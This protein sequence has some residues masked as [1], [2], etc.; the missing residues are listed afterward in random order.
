MYKLIFDKVKSIIPKI[1][2][3]E[4]IALR[5]GGVSIDRQIFS[6][7]VNYKTIKK[8]KMNDR[9]KKMVDLTDNILN[10]IGQNT[11]FPTNNYKDIMKTLGEKG[12]LSLIIDEKFGGNK[13]S[14]TAQSKIISKISS[15][16]PALG[17]VVMVPNSLGPAELLQHYGSSHQKEY[18]LP[19]LA[20]GELIPCFGLTGPNNGSDAVGQIDTGI[21]KLKN[22]KKVIEITLNKR[23]I[24]LAPISNLVGV[25]FN[26]KDPES[27]LLE[28]K[29]GITIALLK[30][31]TP[32]LL[33]NTFHNPNNVGFPNGT[34]K[35]TVDV[36]FTEVIGGEKQIGKGWPML[37]EC[38]AVGRG[39]SLPACANGSSKLITF[40][41][42][43]Y[44]QHRTQFKLP[45]GEMEGVKEKFINMFLQTWIIHCSVEFTNAILD[46]GSTPSVIT[47]IMKQQCTERGRIVLN[48]AMDIYAGSGICIGKNNF[49]TSFYNSTPIGITVEGSNTL[50]RSLIIFGQGLNKSHPHI[51]NIFDSIQNN[52]QSKFNLN[53]NK[54]LRDTILNY[55]SSCQ[56][57]IFESNSAERRLINLTTKFSN[58]SNFVALLG[59]KIKSNQMI[60]GN[61][62]DILSNIYLA[63]SVLWYH[64]NNPDLNLSN[65]KD[66][67]I[68]KLCIDA[69]HKL[70]LVIQNYPNNIIKVLLLP[71]QSSIRYN[72]FQKIN[73]IYESI[74]TNQETIK[75]IIK[76]D[77][78]YDK[79][80]IIDNLNNNLDSVINV[81][82]YDVNY[83]IE[84]K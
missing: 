41:I 83:V 57:G 67:V 48:E 51:F 16:N 55:L 9:E 17:V 37:M 84:L 32:G 11:Y 23:Y 21:V 14:I 8:I 26:L 39:V 81:G 31:T 72:N 42:L 62:A 73:E 65:V 12:F 79:D 64:E 70:N 13:I 63:Y 38:L 66:F 5:S 50:T 74:K 53:F 3:T 34:V 6:G 69:E 77:I 43:N 58:L 22:G 19:K 25:A 44:I 82:E 68:E 80:S 46:S 35:G 36:D 75:T 33:Q 52:D 59:G 76:D 61:M 18:Y 24:T 71:T 2:Q 29:E 47:A 60:S 4:L 28:G 15:Y 40:G 1:S 45:I 49:L 20:I 56:L 10:E 54:M 7:K 27:L 78:Y 30:N